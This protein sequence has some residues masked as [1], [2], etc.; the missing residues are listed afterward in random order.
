[1]H[2]SFF[3]RAAKLSPCVVRPC[4][5][6]WIATMGMSGTLSLIT[7]VNVAFVGLLLLPMLSFAMKCSAKQFGGHGE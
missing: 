6:P 3:L 4:A 5:G 1:M 2:R 7:V